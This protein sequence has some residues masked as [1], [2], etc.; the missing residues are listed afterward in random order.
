M[1]G[2]LL[3]LGLGVIFVESSSSRHFQGIVKG[4][5]VRGE[6]LGMAVEWVVGGMKVVMNSELISRANF[7]SH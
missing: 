4:L 3:G 7:K 5:E 1:V 2:W 6:G